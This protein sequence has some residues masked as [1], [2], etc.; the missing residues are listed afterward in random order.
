MSQFLD[1]KQRP[2]N[3]EL[4]APTIELVRQRTCPDNDCSH[5]P[6]TAPC[7][8]LDLAN[9]NGKAMDRLA[10]DPVLLVRVLTMLCT[11]QLQTTGIT[12]TDFGQS[13]VGDGLGRATDAMLE[14]IAG[15]FHGK[16]RELARAM[17]AKSKKV[18]EL[19]I[20]KAI[21]KIEDPRLETQLLDEM[22]RRMEA[23]LQRALTQSGSATT[24]PAGSA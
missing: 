7:R 2:W 13:L 12:A 18:V 9:L 24:S 3:L 5:D 20:T 17:A 22:D 8:G 6:Y 1:S 11:E 15:F 16:K 4:D 19:G 21:G 14:S 23:A 10:E